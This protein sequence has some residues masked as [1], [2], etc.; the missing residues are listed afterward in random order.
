MNDVIGCGYRPN[1]QQVFFTKNGKDL[2]VAYTGLS[3]IWYPTIGSNG[4]CGLKIN[5]GQEEFKY[6]EASGMRTLDNYI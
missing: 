6:K 4:I 1:T 3:Y 2:G 5:F